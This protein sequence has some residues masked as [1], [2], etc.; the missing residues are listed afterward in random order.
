MLF[1]LLVYSPLVTVAALLF[2]LI[3]LAVSRAELLRRPAALCS[4]VAVLLGGAAHLVF[5]RG[6]THI[7]IMYG[8]SKCRESRPEWMSEQ[9]RIL[10]YDP[11]TFPPE[12]NCVWDNGTTSDLVPAYV[13]PTV[14]AL[15]LPAVGCALVALY[16]RLRRSTVHGSRR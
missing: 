10:R 6:L 14:Y 9:V 7:P 3:R 5:T 16:F 12:A 1:A 15:L 13:T 2:V 4:Y 8:I 11:R